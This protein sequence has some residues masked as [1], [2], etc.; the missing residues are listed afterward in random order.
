[1]LLQPKNIYVALASVLQTHGD[2][3]FIGV[4]VEVRWRHNY[5][6][7]VSLS[8]VDVCFICQ[9][10]QTTVQQSLSAP[11]DCHMT[12]SLFL[13]FVYLTC[14]EAN[15]MAL[16]AC[17]YPAEINH[18][19]LCVC[20]WDTCTAWCGV[21]RC[22]AARYRTLGE[23]GHD[24][25]RGIFRY[26]CFF[27]RYSLQFRPKR[28]K[29]CVLWRGSFSEASLCRPSADAQCTN[30]RAFPRLFL[31]S[32]PKTVSKFLPDMNP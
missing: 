23:T 30:Y 26:T 7:L 5:V 1:M 25:L 24:Q 6:F 19:I 3:E 21:V 11:T 16:A 28:R 9:S 22:G 20:L 2:L 18:C 12:P 29:C 4:M 8:C 27:P 32:L 10:M 31:R 15:Q 13:F 14:S 17:M